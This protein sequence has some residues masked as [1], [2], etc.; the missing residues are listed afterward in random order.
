MRKLPYLV[1]CVVALL[2]GSG[3][4]AAGPAGGPHAD[5]KN[6]PK[7]CASCH[8][9]HGVPGE[10][11]LPFAEEDNC[12]ECHGGPSRTLEAKRKGKLGQ[13]VTTKDLDA[14][15]RKPSNHP[16]FTRGRH[17][18]TE[19]IA[20]AGGERHAE[21]VDCHNHHKVDEYRLAPGAERKRSPLAVLQ[22]EYELCYRCHTSRSNAAKD[23]KVAFNLANRSFHPIE[24]RSKGDGTGLLAPWTAQSVLSCTDCHGN[25][26]KNGPQGPH[27]S[28][29]APLL[30]ARYDTFAGPESTVRYDLCYTCHSRTAL[31]TGSRFQGHRVHVQGAGNACAECHDSHG[32]QFNRALIEFKKGQ[33]LR[34]SK[35]GRLEFISNA[36]GTGTCYLN[37]HGKEHDP[38][39]Y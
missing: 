16:I 17:R 37:C 12:F 13:D 8:M 30:I 24:A 18:P 27:G 7:G 29:F 35:G 2:A 39:S 1:I 34:P 6:I 10:K 26:D 5:P 11:M 14:V 25:D 20:A 15:F 22:F 31:F 3:R 9:G 4:S 36:P 19:G 33:E 38:L 21:C 28:N 23:M 32:S